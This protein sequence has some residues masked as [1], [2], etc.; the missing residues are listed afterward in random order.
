M[1][2]SECQC[3]NRQFVRNDKPPGVDNRDR[4]HENRQASANYSLRIG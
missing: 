4:D 3:C 2:E 1:Q